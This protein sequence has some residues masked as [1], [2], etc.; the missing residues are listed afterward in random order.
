MG[1]RHL[2]CIFKNG[3]YRLANYGQWDGYP[4]G[5]GLDILRFL[6]DQDRRYML[7][8]LCDNLSFMTEEDWNK[9]HEKYSDMMGSEEYSRYKNEYPE[10]SRDLGSEILGMILERD[11]FLKTNNSLRFAA[12]SLF[13]EWAY[14]ID[15]DKGTFEVYKGFN[16]TKL[17]E[18]ERFSCLEII[19]RKTDLVDQYYP[20]KFLAEFPLN[21]LPTEK[22]FIEVCDPQKEE[23]N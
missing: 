5:Q 15:F 2:I 6:Q 21:H 13:C 14:M 3:E 7:S 1:T 22:E 19:T 4:D 17:N 20:V 12:D 18:K 23:P 11:G 9:V 16:K 10:L 8:L